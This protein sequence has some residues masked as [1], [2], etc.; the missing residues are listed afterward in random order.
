MQLAL[1]PQELSPDS[2]LGVLQTRRGSANGATARDLVYLVTHRFNAADERRLRQIIEKLRRDGHAI[3]AHPSLGYYIAADATEL[4]RTCT[5]LLHR[6][7][8]S[9]EQ[10]SA[11][12]RVAMPDLYGQMGLKAP[13]SDEEQ[14][15]A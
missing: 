3:C 8:T 4:D 2:V 10:V 5:F 13:D 6:A 15:H 7:M 1:L 9:I 11:M 12:K 14:T